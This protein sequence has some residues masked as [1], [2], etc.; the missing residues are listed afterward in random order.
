MPSIT[1]TYTTGKSDQ[2]KTTKITVSYIRNSETGGIVFW[3]K[4]SDY[5]M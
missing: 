2:L 4:S 5:T 3:A 1:V